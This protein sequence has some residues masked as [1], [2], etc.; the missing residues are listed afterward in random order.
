M[1]MTF[2]TEG[3]EGL[4]KTNKKRTATK[5]KGSGLED[6]ASRALMRQGGEEGCYEKQRQKAAARTISSEILV[7]RVEN[8]ERYDIQKEPRRY[9]WKV[10]TSPHERRSGKCRDFARSQTTGARAAASYRL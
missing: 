4:G 9:R 1:M 5:S 2:I 10:L 7:N 8:L 6:G 3:G